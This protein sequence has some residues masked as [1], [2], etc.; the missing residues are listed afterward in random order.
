MIYD[1]IYSGPRYIVFYIVWM[2]NHPLSQ[3]ASRSVGAVT[4]FHVT[5]Y[6]A[7]SILTVVATS[8]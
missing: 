1:N 7:S 2:L 3:S 6:G 8:R 4:R 5:G